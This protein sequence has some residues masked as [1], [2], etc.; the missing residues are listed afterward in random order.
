MNRVLAL[1]DLPAFGRVAL[2]LTIP[3]LEKKGIQVCA[4]PTALLSTHGAYP[5]AQLQ[6]QT[7]YLEK[8]L[9]HLRGLKVDFQALY[10]GFVADQR[11]FALVQDLAGELKR[12]G[13]FILVDPILGDHG[14]LYGLFTPEAVPA[15][16]ALAA[17]ADLITPNLTEA[18]LLLGKPAHEGPR[19]SRELAQWLGEL[20]ELGTEG[21]RF[22]VLTSAP[23]FGTPGH[24][25][26]A[27]F[28]RKTG[29]TE[30]FSKPRLEKGYPG[31]GDYLASVLLARY[32]TTAGDPGKRFF[33]A[34]RKAGDQ[35]W[36]V[37][38]LSLKTGQDPR[39]GLDQI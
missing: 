32:L 28:D 12:K 39:E 22:V 31:T 36:K 2:A 15:M 5:G 23:V 6:G 14:K 16:G 4:L 30:V 11:Q 25:G 37:I 7:A 24:L 8:S 21:P 9:D 10:T 26:I 38:K 29:R 34:V 3:L 35:V 17:Q 19:N 1:S 20:S 18:A 33:Q 13:A 27:A